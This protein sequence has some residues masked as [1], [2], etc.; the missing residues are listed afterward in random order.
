MSE[1]L[2]QEMTLLIVN[3]PKCM[4]FAHETLYILESIRS[5]RLF[6]F[7]GRLAASCLSIAGNVALFDGRVR[8]CMTSEPA[9]GSQSAVW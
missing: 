3:T 7:E 6:Y 4:I 1:N 5:Y 9:A 8:W 2:S